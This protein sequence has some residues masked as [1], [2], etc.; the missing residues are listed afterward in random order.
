MKKN[1]ITALIT[2]MA[3]AYSYCQNS[4]LSIYKNLVDK[5]WK[6]EGTWGDGSK[7]KQEI[8]FEYH[9][10]KSIVIAKTIGYTNKAQTK[11]GER[12][13]GIRKY[14]ATSKQIKFWEFDV[15]GGVTTGK[16]YL[17]GKN[18]VHQYQYGD[19]TTLTDMWEY[20]DDSTYNLKIGKYKNGIWEQVYLNTP[21]KLVNIKK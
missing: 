3:F 19:D 16:I 7:L 5:T 10:N 14:D 2:L 8:T 21:I 13:Y 15:F 4:D 1:Y 17:E 12:N 9:L 18:I 11:F 6:L 20:V